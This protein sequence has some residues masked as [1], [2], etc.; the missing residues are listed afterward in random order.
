MISRGSIRGGEVREL[1][2]ECCNKYGV[3]ASLDKPEFLVKFISTIN[4]EIKSLYL[5]LRKAIC[6]VTTQH[7][8]I[9]VS[10]Q[11]GPIPR[12]ASDFS[13]TE[14]E[15]FKKLV[16]GIIESDVGKI[17]SIRA[18]NMADEVQGR[19]SKKD[20]EKMIE[21]MIVDKWLLK[22][23]GEI[24]MTIRCVTELDPY[25]REAFSDII[26]M[27]DNCKQI[28][29]QGICCQ[30]CDLRMHKHC[31]KKRFQGINAPKCPACNNLLDV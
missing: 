23:E 28:S 13:Q 2:K 15:Y 27:C 4:N 31:A 19:F 8:L 17:S 29:L 18:L 26:K 25:L 30:H 22:K 21:R 1:C 10:C 24:S 11:N 5:E 6:E 7:Y 9:L 3:E 16:E 20:A 12:L 14:L